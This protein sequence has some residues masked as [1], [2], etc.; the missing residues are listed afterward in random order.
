MDKPIGIIG[1]GRSSEYIKT[2]TRIALENQ[3]EI[4][5][6]SLNQEGFKEQRLYDL[7]NKLSNTRYEKPIFHKCKSC[8]YEVVDYQIK[9]G[10]C[11]DCRKVI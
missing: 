9:D 5:K 2:I 8:G 10:I 7:I 1:H 6:D 11:D 3:S 4:I